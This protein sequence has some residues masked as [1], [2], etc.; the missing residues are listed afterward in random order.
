MKRLLSILGETLKHGYLLFILALALYPLLLMLI[1]SFKSNEQFQLNPWFFDPVSQ[2]HWENWGK[3]WDTVS[4]YIANSIFVTVTAVFLGMVMTV[5]SSYV[6]ARYRFPGR[7]LIYYG[8]IASMFLPGTAA[9]L[10]TLFSLLERMGMINTLWALVLVFSIGGQITGIFIVKQFIEDIPRELFETAQMDGAG[11]YHQIVHVV[12][13]MSGSILG[14]TTIMNF[15]GAWNQVI[16]PLILLRD[17]A[18]LTLPV[19]LLRL[20]GEY[21]K[22]YGEMM[23]GYAIASA[24]LLLLFLFMMRLFV[25]GLSSVSIR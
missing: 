17:D 18:L 1:V 16:L 11:H 15:L 13:P 19:G 2:W 12:L 10:I 9:T 14:V 5:L 3:A 24:P 21:V 4:I 6:I 25:K 20:E 7:S 23:A 22:H 8:V